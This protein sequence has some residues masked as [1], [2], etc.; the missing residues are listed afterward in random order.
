MVVINPFDFF[1]D[2][3]AL[4]YP[5]KYEPA[6]VVEL[7]PYLEKGGPGPRL[8]AL[9]EEARGKARGN[10]RN[11]DLLVALNQDLQRR[12]RYD[13]RMEPGVFAP[14]ETLERGHGSCRDFAWL[15]VHLMR[16][17]GFAT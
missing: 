11:V 8:L 16:H 2:E 4:R 15:A 3:A 9:V 7:A 12:L 1:V 14:E 6:L 17:L 5:F 13:I 10:P